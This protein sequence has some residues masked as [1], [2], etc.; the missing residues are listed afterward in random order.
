MRKFLQLIRP[1]RET[2]N[3]V[4][5]CLAFFLCAGSIW[6]QTTIT[7]TAADQGYENG[8]AITSVDFDDNVTGEFFAGSNSNAPKYY[9][10]GSAI[11]CYGGNYFTISTSAGN[12]TEIVLTFASGEGSNDITTDVGTYENGTWSGEASSVTFSI[13]G[14]SG[15]RRIASFSIA[16]VTSASSVAAPTFSPANG[17]TFGNEGLTV[18]IS[19][20]NN[21]PVY[22]TL[23][24]STPSANTANST[25]YS[26]P[27]T[28][29]T[30]TTIKA[31]AYD[32]S[33][34][35]N[36]ATAT[37][38]YIDPSTPG[39]ES[40]PY[41]VAQAR[42]AI[43]ANSGT[44][45][46]YATGIVSAIPTAY[47]SQYGNIT[48]NFVDEAGDEDFLQAYRC[49]GAEAANVAV[50]DIVVVYGNLTKYNTTYEFGQGCQLVSLTHPTG[51]VAAPT[52]S[53]EA[54]MYSEPQTVTLA[55]TTPGASIYYTLDG[56]EPDDESLLYTQPI[57]VSTTTTINAIAYVG[58]NASTVATATYSFVSLANIS[59]ITEVGAA[60]EV[61]GTV[62][63]TNSRGF[64]MGD[65]TGY[66][67]YYNNGAVSQSI[68]DMVTV[69]G[70]TGPYG[71][72]IQFTNTATISVATSSNYNGTPAATLITEIPDY[73]EGFHISD[74]F[75]FE[76]E[77]SKTGN[78]YFI[79]LGEGQIQIS[80][81]TT[82][83]GNTL[84]SM[85]GNIV[86]VKGYFSGINSSDKFTIM[87]ESVEAEA[88]P[89]IT[90]TPAT[91]NSIAEGSDGYLTV[92]Y[93]NIPDLISFDIQFC[94]A[95]GGELTVDPDWI[96]AEINEPT[97][98]EGYTVFYIVNTNEGDA[99]TAYFKVYADDVYSN[100]VTVNQDGYV[101]PTVATLPF[102]FN[103]GKAA[104]DTTDGLTQEGLGSDYAIS[105][106]PT[107]LLK[108]DGTGDWL[109]L[110]F[111]GTPGKLSFDIKGN[112]FSGGTFTVQTSEDGVTYS[113]LK[114]YTT[115]GNT[116]TEEFNTLGADV[117][118][119]KWIYTEKAN[120][121]VGLGNI[122]LE[123][124]STAP[125]IIVGEDEVEVSYEGGNGT[126]TVTY[127]N[128]GDSPVAEVEFYAEDG[129]SFA[130]YDWIVAEID[131]D[132]NLYYVV[133]ANE[134][135]ART[136]YLRVYGITTAEDD[137]AYS[138]LVTISQAAA[139]QQYEL[140]VSEFENLEIF[141]FVDN[142]DELALEGA[143]TITLNEGASVSLSVSANEG[144]VLSTLVVDGQ[145]VLSQLD[146]S[147]LYTFTM[148]GHD[149][150]VT[151][152][153]I[154]YVPGNWVLTS[155]A[156]LT[157]DD[158]FVIVETKDGVSKA[159]PSDN[160]AN[161]APAA[162]DVTVV[163]DTLSGEPAANL[164]WNLSVSNDGY[165][166]YPNGTTESWLYCNNTNNGVRVGGTEDNN[167][168]TV[169]EEG[170]L[171]NIGT[172]RYIG[173]Y[174][175]QDWRC[176]TSIN[177][178]IAGQTFAFYKK[179]A[180]STDLPQTIALNN[181]TN[182][183]SFNVEITLNDLKAALIEAAPNTTI[184]I[185]GQNNYTTYNPSNHRWLGTLSWD[186][187]KMYKIQVTTD[188][189]ISLEG[190]PI[191]PA[192]YTVTIV[193][194]NNYLGFPFNQNMTLT[195]AFA[196][197]AANGDKVLSQTGYA[198]YNRGRWQ[199]TTLT[200]LQPG[201]GYIYK[202]AASES[203]PFVF[204]NSA[205]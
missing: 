26:A 167:V 31:I 24:G 163:G 115:L 23:D 7:W 161:A 10:T 29:T 60:Y 80:Y 17:T 97:E 170:Y 20:A 6:A 61:Q 53:P 39:T 147:G 59:D 94:D 112:G 133:E 67:Y 121:N 145:S 171:Y 56:S 54:G 16:Y 150:T 186:L 101:A 51:F 129:E 193:N 144:Y 87:L 113:D 111:D 200:Q 120:G 172:E 40:T 78:N 76:G 141:T 192:D 86:H 64:I 4:A 204:P 142:M 143:G 34:A 74:Y 81:P 182:W 3:I 151:A 122:V 48:F 35:S 102:Q 160:G 30:T 205:R 148:P 99:R 188:C 18:T 197:F 14:T 41:T 79:A 77:L 98:T 191:D 110:Y 100:I 57:T 8:Q 105:T 22:Y 93:E 36:V 70:I 91:I 126:I 19:Q 44:Q 202:S 138:N 135:E 65:G 11:R 62:V 190:T 124:P 169:S 181:G 13:G 195:N 173:V 189:E 164:Q 139:P 155:L 177:N 92:T 137:E 82:A 179:V 194:G 159:L 128:M 162:V 168:F 140:T 153:A 46:V 90:V 106:N 47:N 132:N 73:T 38:T 185:I 198:T 33:N 130:T 69:S 184:K 84:T 125:A 2:R 72:I 165:T 27:I 5:L 152:T 89:S 45:G 174:N 114:T 32:G 109:E 49:A 50:G 43:D 146:E 52:F 1:F 178:N 108:F 136:A 199:G 42:A 88:V 183:V 118:Y 85:V 15:H 180:S 58:G 196:G 66:V 131:G 176:Y 119:I 75:E 96:S 12:L 37:Y 83:Q 157:E 104:I 107:T 158:V 203:R 63:A 71:H 21:K 149:V 123:E 127:L 68:G 175:N 9:N 95:N 156:D 25:L 166:F 201:K 28:I 117:R 103:A 154:E 55:C 187:S 134:G 116:Q